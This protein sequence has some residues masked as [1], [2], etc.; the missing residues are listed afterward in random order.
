MCDYDVGCEAIANLCDEAARTSHGGSL[1]ELGCG[2]LTYQ[3]AG[4]PAP[5]WLVADRLKGAGHSGNIGPKL[6]ARATAANVN[7]VL[8][9]RGPDLPHK[10][11]V[12]D[13]SGRLP[14]NQLS[15]PARPGT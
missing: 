3:L 1:D 13:P 6:R 11:D 14:Q 9:R 10:V 7:L 8:W 4:K 2:W 15:W 12:Y 5:S